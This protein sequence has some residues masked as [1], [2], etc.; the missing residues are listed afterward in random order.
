MP[1][2]SMRPARLRLLAAALGVAVWSA[3]ALARGPDGFSDLAE[4]LTPAVVNIATT[5]KEAAPRQTGDA[6]RDAPLGEFFHEFFGG[7]DG[8]GN[9]EGDSENGGPG[10]DD[11]PTLPS[12]RAQSLGSG[13]IIDPSGF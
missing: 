1:S 11:A 10:G 3:P 5:H 7:R 9:G 8:T 13:F 6:A 2:G 4:K 12:P